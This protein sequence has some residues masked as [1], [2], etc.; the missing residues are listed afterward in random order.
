MGWYYKI[1]CLIVHNI[2]WNTQAMTDYH[3]VG[4]IR[5]RKLSQISRKWKKFSQNAK[6]RIGGWDMPKFVVKT[7]AGDSQIVKFMKFFSLENFPL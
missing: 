4:N 7:F 5:G 3:I 2:V 6:S 1:I